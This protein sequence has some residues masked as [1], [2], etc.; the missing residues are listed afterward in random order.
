[1]LPCRY[2]LRR[3][4]AAY[5]SL[6]SNPS[7]SRQWYR[8]SSSSQ[9]DG[10]GGG[11]V[12]KLLGGVVVA[13]VAGGAVA[14]YPFLTQEAQEEVREKPKPKPKDVELEYEKER[15]QVRSKEENRDQ[16]SNQHL[17]LKRSWENPGVYVWGSNT[18]KVADPGSTESVVKAPRRLPYF[19][20]QLLRDLKLDREFGAAVT[21]K[22]DLVQWGTGYSKDNPSPTITL[23]G[24]DLVKIGISAD[25]IIGLGKDGSVYSIP[26]SESDQ[27]SGHKPTPTSSYWSSF[28]TTPP[29]PISY[30]EWKPDDL[31]RGETITDVAA[32]LEHALLL[33]SK[34]RLFSAAASTIEFPSKGQ[35][36]IP[37]L[38]WDTRPPG[39]FDQLHEISMPKGVKI[40]QIAAG[41]YHSLAL[42]DKGRAYV[43]GDN[44]L[45]QLGF[46]PERVIPYIDGPVPLPLN[47]IY[48]GSGTQSTV[49]SIEAGG[50]NSF[51]TVDVLPFD[52]TWR[53]SQ[54]W[55]GKNTEPVRADTWACG[56]GIVGS[57]GNGKLTH[58]S[59]GPTKIRLLSGLSEWNQKSGALVPIRLTRLSAGSTHAAAVI[60]N[61]THV[62]P[63]SS[64]NSGSASDTSYGADVLFWGGNEHY[65]LGTGRRLNMPAPTYIGPLDG[66]GRAD[67]DKDNRL[68]VAPRGKGRIGADGK[69]RKVTM[70]QRV[71]CGR[72]VSAVYSAT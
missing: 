51:L 33:T 25:R 41:D 16:I 38:K 67:S 2:V 24:K 61:A 55:G 68:Q 56:A 36:G 6:K 54:L 52:E 40:K 3:T 28:W 29:S 23:K 53:L 63:A 58:V 9:S 18:G 43:F 49:T 44:S 50:A 64:S 60:G 27:A 15:P 10:G 7:V 31:S 8:Y 57:L 66:R 32:G 62:V 19:D 47:K 17:Q 22:G 14:L 45:G 35:L 26:V 72:Y 59:P 12:G 37:G 4:P 46:E 20:G 30:R 65:Q 69:G 70:E 71:E 39:P 1:M 42:D 48:D 21:E 13:G 5:R 34:G 11:F